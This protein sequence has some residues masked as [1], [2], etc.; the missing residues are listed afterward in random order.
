MLFV[1][2]AM[3]FLLGSL[4][5]CL[6]NLCIAR[7]PYEK[8]I[9]WPSARC[10]HCRQSVPLNDALPLINY[11]WR[12]G[13]CRI[14]GARLSKKPFIIEV[15]TGLAF[16]TLFYLVVIV[17]IQNLGVMQRPIFDPLRV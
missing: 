10:R 9:I 7:L 5:G 12:G 3:I 2:F 8:S 15:L 16:M 4:V 11:W 1:L 17:D 13:C 14:C 6:L